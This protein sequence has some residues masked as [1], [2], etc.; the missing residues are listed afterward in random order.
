MT[1]RASWAGPICVGLLALTLAL[2]PQPAAADG[3]K[4]KQVEA[5]KKQMAELQKQLAD[6]EKA[7]EPAKPA[8]T[9]ALPAAVGQHFAWRN[10]GPA[11]MGGRVTSLAVVESEP[12][13]YYVGTG[14]G[15]LLK[16]VNNGTT[17][18]VLFD[19]Q[20]TVSIGDVAVAPSDPNIVWVGSGEANPRNSVSY[21]DGVYKSTDAGKTF[22]KMGLDK[23]YQIGKILIH[24]KDPNTVYVGA[25]GRLYGPNPDRGMYKTTDGG[26]TWDKVLFVDDKTG[27]IDARFDP[28]N[29][30]VVVAALWERKRDEFDGFFGDAP[31]PDTYGPIVTHGKGGGLY[32]TSD[33]GKTWA[34][35]KK[36]LPSAE[37]GR[38]GLD[39][40]RATKG[41]LYAVIDTEK[42]G[43]GE[44]SKVYL[45]VTA[46]EL[47]E[48]TKGAKLG[49]VTE[50]G[51]SEKSGLKSG[52]VIVKAGDAEIVRYDDFIDICYQREPG[53]E[54][55][56][57][58]KRGDKEEAVTLKLGKRDAPP[59]QAPAGPPVLGV[60]L[61]RGESGV[62]FGT[63]QPNG[64]AAKAGVKADDA[65][66]AIDGKP[67]KDGKAFTLAM[68]EMK[69]GQVI[70]LTLKRGTEEKKVK[71]TLAAA[72]GAT[73]TL[74]LPGFAPVADGEAVKVG[75]LV[76]GGPA[77]K[78]G[79][80]EGDVVTRVGGEPVAGLRGFFRA[81]NVGPG[82]E[83]ARQ[84]GTKLKLSIKSGDAAEKEFELELVPV[85]YEPPAGTV[86]RGATANRP[87][88]LGLGGQQANVQFRQGKDGVE[89]G[90][91][92]K[93]SDF[94][95]TWERVN[96]PQPAADVFFGR[97]RR[98][99]RR[100]NHLHARR[101]ADDLEVD[102]RRQALRA[103]GQLP[104]RP[105]R[106]ARAGRRPEEPQAH[107]H[108]LRRR[109]LR[110]L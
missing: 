59:A 11:N 105:R 67:V 21:G 56:L 17:F 14:T 91:L 69:A 54:I 41:V 39:A 66:T 61:K 49:D 16:T 26:K 3:E 48:G 30:D 5:I 86:A 62:V 79:I 96:S 100:Q 44:A 82:V 64:A 70:E 20:S 73:P 87:Y 93:S 72:R 63:V 52:D 77:A 58:V 78:A 75:K 33:A 13:T 85:P 15:G 76:E 34:Q 37:T 46:G 23:T 25:L 36:G 35:I 55:K 65:L 4:A 103:D 1:P 47:P 7:G 97:P 88:G 99:G 2:L 32:K 98:P 109:V 106:R 80:K 27:V 84:S 31:V 107:D 42:V 102:R 22:T 43:T 110:Q 9:A 95:D 104:R 60:T 51:P 40:S 50:G 89:T 92:Y 57:V 45:G 71:V 74:P 38:I 8:E 28:N 83:D 108:R 81:L 90:G 10:V 24:P 12:T 53:D 6:L 19:Q 101:R 94:G 18:E 29:P 68:R